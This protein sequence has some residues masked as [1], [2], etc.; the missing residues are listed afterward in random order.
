MYATNMETPCYTKPK[1]YLFVRDEYKTASKCKSAH[2]S[3]NCET[4]SDYPMMKLHYPVCNTIKPLFNHPWDL[5]CEQCIP[6]CPSLKRLGGTWDYLV[7]TGTMEVGGDI[8][9]DVKDYY[10]KCILPDQEEF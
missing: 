6:L 3:K 5:A 7:E 2:G 1:N 8:L 10:K 9:D 4:C